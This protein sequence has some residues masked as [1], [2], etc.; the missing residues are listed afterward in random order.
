MLHRTRDLLIRQRT[1][2][3]NALRAHLAV[4]LHQ[5]VIVTECCDERLEQRALCLSSDRFTAE[6][7]VKEA[8]AKSEVGSSLGAVWN[9]QAEPA[10]PKSQTLI[11]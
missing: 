8:M 2:L 6:G 7:S 9:P 1:L 4:K 11:L 5:L 10:L 3:I